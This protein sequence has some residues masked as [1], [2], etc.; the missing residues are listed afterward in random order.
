MPFTWTG[1]IGVNGLTA[2]NFFALPL[3]CQNVKSYEQHQ[4]LEHLVYTPT[5][6]D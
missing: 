5:G 6:F 3:A 2:S 4:W 1:I